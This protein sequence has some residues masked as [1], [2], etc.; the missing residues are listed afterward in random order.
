M[1]QFVFEKLV[2]EESISSEELEK[3]YDIIVYTANKDDRSYYKEVRYFYDLKPEFEIFR[4]KKSYGYYNKNRNK[5]L[6]LYLGEGIRLVVHTYFDSPKGATLNP[7]SD[8][9]LSET[10]Y[11]FKGEDDILLQLPKLIAYDRQGQIKMTTYG[12]LQARNVGKMQ[13]KL[14]IKEFYPL[15]KATELKNLRSKLMASLILNRA[16]IIAQYNDVEQ[17]K[18]VVF[19]YL[20]KIFFKLSSLFSLYQRRS[21]L[22]CIRIKSCF[23][24]LSRLY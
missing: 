10:D 7:L 19:K 22:I 13:R 8:S 11:I 18:K 9:D 16:F 14:S 12:F 4:E 21:K 1:F 15:T 17:L 24:L 2:W 5:N 6:N 20:S 23:I 3:K